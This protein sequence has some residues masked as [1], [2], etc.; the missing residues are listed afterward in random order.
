MRSCLSHTGPQPTY[1]HVSESLWLTATR[2]LQ[3]RRPWS[4]LLQAHLDSFHSELWDQR[5]HSLL[6]FS[7]RDGHRHLLPVVRHPEPGPLATG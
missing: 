2:N 6:G 3:C 1:P 7:F 5:S 4:G